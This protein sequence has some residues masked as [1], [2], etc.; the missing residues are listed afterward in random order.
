[1]RRRLALLAG[2]VALTLCGAPAL[3]SASTSQESG[4][5]D[6][7]LL[8]FSAPATMNATLDSL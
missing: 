6:D 5:Q 1:M 2:A 4:F 8:I 3:A 7:P